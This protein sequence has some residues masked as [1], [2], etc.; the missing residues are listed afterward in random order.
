MRLLEVDFTLPHG[1]DFDMRLLEVD[2]RLQRGTD[3][4]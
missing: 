4:K 1:A 2:F 3:F